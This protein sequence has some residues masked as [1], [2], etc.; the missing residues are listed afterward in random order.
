[1]SIASARA[2]RLAALVAERELDAVLAAIERDKKRTAAG[3]GF[4]VLERPGSIAVGQSVDE[5]RVRAAVE[6]LKR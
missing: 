4:V 1:M 6:E 3:I 2:D 5:A